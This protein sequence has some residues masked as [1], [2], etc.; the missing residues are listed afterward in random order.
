MKA[1]IVG[2]A[3]PALADAEAALFRAHLPAGVILFARN[4]VDPPQLRA[5]TAALRGALPPE[6]VLMVDQE[7]GRVA[8]LRAPY[9]RTHPPAAAIGRAFFDNAAIG[10]RAA[11]LTG[12]LIGYDLSL[13]HI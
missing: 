12:A 9:W 8:R 1:A 13:I 5:L 7:G 2:V 10:S 3:G 4:I 6:A 11:W